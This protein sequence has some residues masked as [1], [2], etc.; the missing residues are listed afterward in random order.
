MV[1]GYLKIF[2]QLQTSETAQNV[3]WNERNVKHQAEDYLQVTTQNIPRGTKE[4]CKNIQWE[5][6]FG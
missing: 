5:K 6:W 1:T 4:M 2:F 3:R